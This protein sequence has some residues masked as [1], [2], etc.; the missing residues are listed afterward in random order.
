MHRTTLWSKRLVAAAIAVAGLA[1][2]AHAATITVNSLADDVFPDAAGNLT[3]INNQPVILLNPKCTLRMAVASAN[4]DIAVGG[5]LM[6]C[7]AGSPGA[8]TIL[9]DA[10]LN[11]ATTPGTITFADR[12]MSSSLALPNI[13]NAP[14]L[15]VTSALTITGPGS[16]QLT[17]DGS[18]AGASSRRIILAIDDNFTT[19]FQLALSGMRLLRGRVEDGIGGCIGS[20][21]GVTLTDVV[22]ESCESVSGGG[23]G[24][25]GGGLFVG[26]A[27]SP[28]SNSRPT[29]TIVNSRFTG[30]RAV[31]GTSA[32]RSEGGAFA[33]GGTPT[34]GDTDFWVGAVNISGTIVSGNTADTRGCGLIA[35]ATSV[36]I[37]NSQFIGNA[38]TGSVAA[39]S[40]GRHG[41]LLINS[42]TGAV[43]ITNTRIATN[44]A[45]EEQAGMGILD[46][47]G[48]I[49][50]DQL[51]VSGNTANRGPVGGLHLLPD[52]SC[53]G[54]GPVGAL[55]ITH[56]RIAGNSSAG[57]A[58]GLRVFCSGPL[59]MSDVLILGN[60]SRGYRLA[61]NDVANG[62]NSALILD[63][64][65]SVNLARVTIL[66]NASCF[67]LG[68]GSGVFSASSIGTFTADSLR[69][70]ENYVGQ[71]NGIW[72]NGQS[73]AST[74]LIVNSEIS[75][76]SASSVPAVFMEG[77]GSYT[78][79][80]TTVSGNS[81]RS[82]PGIVKANANTNTPGGI[83]VAIEHSTIARNVASAEE[84]FSV[85]AGANLPN[86]G[87]V[88]PTLFGGGNAA[89]AVRNS[90][91]AGRSPGYTGASSIFFD[92]ANGVTNV[93]AANDVVENSG[94]APAGFCA[95]TGMQCNVGALV[96]PLADNGGANGVRTMALMAGSPAIDHG[97]AVLGGLT[98]DA[99]GTGFPRVV[100]ATVDV[101]AYESD[102]ATTVGCTLD[103]D[104]NGT[105]DALTDGLLFI[106]AAFGLTGNSATNG[107]VGGGAA[108]AN[109]TA[110]RNYLNANCGSNFAQ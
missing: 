4:L 68:N 31:R 18:I 21:K 25:Y 92:A 103:V 47:G 19:T 64:I 109:W 73:A 85:F 70:Y 58:G 56:A 97:G 67:A 1:S 22:F 10:A 24:A 100:N 78:L 96:A 104:G 42:V 91:L 39:N 87:V 32:N 36:T 89:I 84:A 8:D 48:P 9:F 110:I 30:N 37:T 69:F 88:S 63:T 7:A 106:R 71:S 12:G 40:S 44:I 23:Q 3:D 5:A 15:L 86:P 65:P 75:R 14:P 46:I 6:G 16:G 26:N 55:T 28:A 81:A 34:P 17:L 101:G 59:T 74:F 57:P 77:D 98:T 83:H 66:G 33:L 49:T 50:L 105:L 102:A 2:V 13:G 54:A 62:S 27:A 82:G 80:N 53:A 79:R 93:T 43:S 11:L 41:G 60:E 94:G 61:Q 35:A 107:V 38:S 90:I 72:L 20:T 45:N 95:G 29:V 76:N 51:D 108:R 52:V 99:R